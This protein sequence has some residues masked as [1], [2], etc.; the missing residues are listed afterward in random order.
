MKVGRK[1]G[2]QADQHLK[3]TGH[4]EGVDLCGRNIAL[5]LGIL[6]S[7]S[8]RVLL[9]FYISKCPQSLR[10]FSLTVL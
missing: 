9:V 1:T 5:E 7:C 4:W 6:V 10:I 8:Q 3:D 2:R